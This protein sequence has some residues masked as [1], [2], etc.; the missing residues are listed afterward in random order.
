MAHRP[1]PV[2]IDQ[3]FVAQR[4]ATAEGALGEALTH[5]HEDGLSPGARP[6]ATREVERAAARVRYWRDLQ[7]RDSTHPRVRACKLLGHSWVT[8]SVN[9]I[10]L[11][12]CRRCGAQRAD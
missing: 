9:S 1:M 7:H 2:P 8:S 3:R 6:S 11:E 5:L 12:I 10:S 4:L